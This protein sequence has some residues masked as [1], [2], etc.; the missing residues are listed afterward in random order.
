MPYGLKEYKFKGMTY[1]YR[2]VDQ[3]FKEYHSILRFAED[4]LE[5]AI[6]DE[7]GDINPEY[8]YVDD[9]FYFYTSLD[10]LW[11]MT[12]EELLALVD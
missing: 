5:D 2:E 8:Q 4:R 7:N 11:N 3:R 9:L 10:N 1:M 6:K 12:D